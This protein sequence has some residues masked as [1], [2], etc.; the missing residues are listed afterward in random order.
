[1]RRGTLRA[2]LPREGT[3]DFNERRKTAVNF[4]EGGNILG[5]FKNMIDMGIKAFPVTPVHQ[6]HVSHTLG[7]I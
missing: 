6:S 7:C 3:G 4:T 5:E 1:M 2:A